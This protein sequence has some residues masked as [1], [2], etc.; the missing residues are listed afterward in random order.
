[1]ADYKLKHTGSEVDSAIDKVDSNWS[2]LMSNLGIGRW[3][4]ATFRN[5]SWVTTNTIY[6]NMAKYYSD[7]S[8]LFSALSWVDQSGCDRN[9]YD[10]HFSNPNNFFRKEH[11]SYQNA[12]ASMQSTGAIY[13]PTFYGD[14][15]FGFS[16][17]LFSKVLIEDGCTC[18]ITGSVNGIFNAMPNLTE[19]GAFDMSEYTIAL[20]LFIQASTKVKSIHCTHWKVS[21]NISHSTA[22]EESDLVEIISNLDEVTT[23][24]TL[25]MGATNLAK[26]TDAEKQVA[27]DKGWVLA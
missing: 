19:I 6:D 22:F 21:F 13:M 12:F 5:N 15:S 8:Y 17:S 23:A 1:M 26:L 16:G 25:T 7:C 4:N 10:I 18:K 27:T 14:L 20:S 3:R 2:T 24:Q 9:G 11:T